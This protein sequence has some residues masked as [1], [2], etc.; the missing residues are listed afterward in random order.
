MG[1]A[2]MRTLRCEG[3]AP[4]ENHALFR[5]NR[6]C[7]R[8]PS[9]ISQSNRKKPQALPMASKAMDAMRS[10]RAPVLS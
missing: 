2:D 7:A 10:L 3:A 8:Q 9:P 5:V 1:I 4:T 6:D